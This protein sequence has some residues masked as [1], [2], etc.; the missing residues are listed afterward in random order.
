MKHQ[1]S[2]AANSPLRITSKT[3]DVGGIETYRALPDKKQRLIG[4]WCFLDHLG[5]T[6]FNGS[7]DKLA[8]APHPHI[9][10]Q[11][12]TWML[13]GKILHRDSLGY[14]QVIRPNQVN[15]MT[16]GHGISHSEDSYGDKKEVHL[17]QLWIVLPKDKRNMPPRFD[18][19]PNLP[20]WQSDNA[21]FTLLIGNYQHYT[22][23]VLCLLPMVGMGI[24]AKKATCVSLPLKEKFE[25][26]L[27]VLT[28]KM[29]IE[30]EVFNANELA[31]IET[32]NSSLTIELSND[33]QI[34]FLGGEP[35]NEKI[36]MWWN[37]V[38]R[39]KEEIQNAIADWNKGSER[40]GQVINDNREP[41]VSPLM[42]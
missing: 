5:P 26:G 22:S 27:F 16:A 33:S 39:S 25:Y 32:Q 19:Y 20:K 31:Y 28:G 29:T 9:G 30:N 23:S 40:F 36:L 14:Q 7:V 11:T 1:L 8:I 34:L 38:G 4:P 41:L 6:V 18:H 2:D 35:L 17:A 12:F 21:N 3:R 42:P 15:L 13:E 10:L 37:F 24:T